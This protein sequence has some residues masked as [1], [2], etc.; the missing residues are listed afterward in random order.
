MKPVTHELRNKIKMMIKNKE[1]I[2]D[3]LDNIDI[4]GEDLSYAI[5]KRFNRTKQNLS[6]TKF[7]YAVIGEEGIVTNLSGNIFREC[8]FCNTHFL[9][10]VYMRRCDCRGSNFSCAWMHNVEYQYSD[11]RQCNFCEAILRLG[12]DY[13]YKTKVD[14]NIFL[15]LAKHWNIKVEIKDE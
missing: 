1:D 4:R 13:G 15:D 2:S 10:T 3:L 12:S 14:K 5:I 6:R 9:G 11:M 8:D 7:T